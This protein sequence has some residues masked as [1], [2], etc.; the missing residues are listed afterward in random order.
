M[1]SL[2][3]HVC[4][5]CHVS[6]RHRCYFSGLNPGGKPGGDHYLLLME[7]LR[8][9]LIVPV[10]ADAHAPIENDYNMHRIKMQVYF[11]HFKDLCRKIL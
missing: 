2:V 8:G 7:L 3:T 10:D 9:V 11:S 4:H 1:S 5:K 6:E